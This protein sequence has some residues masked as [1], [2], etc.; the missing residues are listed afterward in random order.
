[1]GLILFA[2]AQQGLALALEGAPL[3]GNRAER[4]AKLASLARNKIRRAFSRPD[5][6]LGSDPFG[7]RR[8]GLGHQIRFLRFQVGQLA[9]D[10]HNALRAGQLGSRQALRVVPQDCLDLVFKSFV[11]HVNF[12]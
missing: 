9:R 11:C 10:C 8:V 1:M 5:S 6:F 12:P 3:L 4:I 2:A 7:S